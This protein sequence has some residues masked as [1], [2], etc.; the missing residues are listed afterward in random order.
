MDP[1]ISL[2]L[3]NCFASKRWTRP[4]DWMPLIRDLG[5]TLVE[6]S[7]DTECDPLHMGSAY[8]SDWVEDVHACAEQWG[9]RVVNLYSGHG[10]YSTLGL[11]HTDNRV[12]NRFRD[13]WLKSQAKTAK[14]LD[15]GLGFFAHAIPEAALQDP[16]L[17]NGAIRR[18]Y[19]DLSELAAFASNI[20]LSNISVEQMYTP[21]QPPWTIRGARELLQAANRGKQAPFFLTLD[22]GHM[23]GQ[24]RFQKPVS[25]QIEEWISQKASDKDLP[26]IW[27]G[28]RSAMDIGLQAV[29]GHMTGKEALDRIQSA[30]QP[31]DHLFAEPQD[32]SV[33][34]WLEV[35]SGYSP[36]IHLQQRDRKSV[37]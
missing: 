30:W 24:S 20:G 17:Y 29:N 28:P 34:A 7:A 21:H 11:A 6:A 23:N 18:L 22:I 2:A 15:A 5:I 8:V 36:I 27:L 3:D 32:G 25:S 10:T 31:Y 19:G 37:V 16:A 13:R 26:W 33:H 12:R 4:C 1:R 35:L 14:K 9:I